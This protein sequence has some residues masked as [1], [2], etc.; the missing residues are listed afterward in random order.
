MGSAA[1]VGKP[2]KTLRIRCCCTCYALG[3]TCEVVAIRG[4]Y[5]MAHG[6]RYTKPSLASAPLRR[7]YAMH[8]VYLVGSLRASP[9]YLCYIFWRLFV[10][11]CPFC[12]CFIS[13]SFC[14]FCLVF[15]FM[16]SL[17]LCRCSSDISLSSR[18]RSTGLATAYSSISLGMVEAR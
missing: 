6:W 7:V 11:F 16:L 8:W 17:E 2:G 15:V 9:S 12:C 4:G 18:P 1:P 10:F 5:R 13:L 14:R 3:Y